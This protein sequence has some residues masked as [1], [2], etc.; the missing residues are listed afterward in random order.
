MGRVRFERR[1][2][3]VFGFT[4]DSAHVRDQELE[5][6]VGGVLECE[7]EHGLGFR[8]QFSFVIIVHHHGQANLAH[9][10]ETGNSLTVALGL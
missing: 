5:H 10:V 3:I 7:V 4:P 1:A 6:I 2:G 8:W 9:V